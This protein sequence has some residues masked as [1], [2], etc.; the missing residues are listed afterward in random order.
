MGKQH[1]D[2]EE[3]YDVNFFIMSVQRYLC[4][5]REINQLSCPELCIATLFTHMCL[6]MSW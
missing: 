4:H 6:I 5:S 3:S 1:V 2:E